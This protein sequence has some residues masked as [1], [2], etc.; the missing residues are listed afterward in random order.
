MT[1]LSSREIARFAPGEHGIA[2]FAIQVMS[3]LVGDAAQASGPP[4]ED[5]LARLV[6]AALTGDPAILAQLSLDFRRLRIPAATAVD[7]YIPAAVSEIGT[8]WHDDVIDILDATIAVTRLQN[9]VREFGRGWQA[10]ATD[11][12][13][14]GSV[15]MVVPEGESHTL[16]AMIATS[17]LRRMGVSVALLL[18]PAARE[19]DHMLETRRFD[20][21]FLSVG[22]HDSLESAATIVKTM[23]RRMSRRLP[24]VAGGSIPVE[25]DV[26]RRA[27]RADFATRDVGAALDFLGMRTSRYAAQ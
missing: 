25:L 8:A 21:L 15:L 6:R 20:G 3:I 22:N 5:L 14:E 4:R 1:T 27:T 16:G 7:V 11:R 9:L 2:Q 24:V 26:V 19:I 17:Q 13:Q 23:E 18:A 12:R 10:D